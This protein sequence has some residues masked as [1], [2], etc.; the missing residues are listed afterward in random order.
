MKLKDV[1][2][3]KAIGRYIL[4]LP[5]YDIKL[6][7][8]KDFT[9]RINLLT[10]IVGGASALSRLT[11]ISNSGINRYL[12]GGEPTVS[13]LKKISTSLYVNLKWLVLGE[14]P[15]VDGENKG[16]FVVK[17]GTPGYAVEVSGIANE[18]LFYEI[19]NAFDSSEGASSGVSLKDKSRDIVEAYNTVAGLAKRQQAD[20]IALFTIKCDLKYMTV[21]REVL[22]KSITT[23]P[24]MKD[25][26][27]TV[28]EETDKQIA[29]LEEKMILLRKS[30]N[31]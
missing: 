18:P 12:S 16:S 7:N 20:A 11:G 17:E 13:Q 8:A 4:S 9:Q 22:A 5:E 31:P 25:Q 15:I 26:F 24:E 2:D 29:E 14:L 23:V 21:H 6:T 10:E 1:N 27:A 28:L 3:P 30:L 19:I